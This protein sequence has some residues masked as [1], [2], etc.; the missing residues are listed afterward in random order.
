MTCALCGS[1]K[2]RLSRRKKPLD[3]GYRLL[4]RAAFRCRD[5]EHRFFSAANPADIPGEME[6]RSAR[7]QRSVQSRVKRWWDKGGRGKVI[8]A[9]VFGTVLIMFFLF[10][11]YFLTDR[12]NR[13]PGDSGSLQR[14]SPGSE[15]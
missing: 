2:I 11:Q 10:M 13:S 8:Q 9:A 3:I 7:K 1:A 5:C 6:R 4:G 15:G 12:A 14:T